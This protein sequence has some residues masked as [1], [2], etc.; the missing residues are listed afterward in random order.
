MSDA[1]RTAPGPRHA[2]IL[3]D[4]HLSDFEAEDPARPGWRRFKARAY[5]PDDRLLALLAHFRELSGGAPI[6]LVLAGDTFDFDTIVALPDPAPPRLTWLERRRGLVPEEDRSTWKIRRILD[7][8]SPAAV[9]L[10]VSSL[11]HALSG[12]VAVR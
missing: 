8:D 1:Y 10:F 7:G 6:E 2:A 5:G 4:V 3:S 12:P 9:G 11:R